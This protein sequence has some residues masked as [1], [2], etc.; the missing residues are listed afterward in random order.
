M[1]KRVGDDPA[2]GPDIV[3]CAS[4]A[5]KEEGIGVKEALVELVG[6]SRVEVDPLEEHCIEVWEGGNVVAKFEVKRDG[7][8]QG[9][10]DRSSIGGKPAVW[11]DNGIDWDGVVGLV[12]SNLERSQV[13]DVGPEFCAGFKGVVVA[14]IE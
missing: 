12:G 14:A 9:G 10:Y 11:T 8:F 5:D 7:F 4:V 6:R 2:S 1:A 13:E 3:V